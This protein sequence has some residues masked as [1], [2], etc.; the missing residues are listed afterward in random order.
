M[1]NTEHNPHAAHIWVREL[2]FLFFN[3]N[4]P[5]QTGKYVIIFARGMLTSFLDGT[6]DIAAH[7]ACR[8]CQSKLPPPLHFPVGWAAFVFV[9]VAGNAWRQMPSIFCHVFDLFDFRVI[10]MR[11]MCQAFHLHAGELCCQRQPEHNPSLLL[12]V[13]RVSDDDDFGDDDVRLHSSALC[14]RREAL[15][16]TH[17]WW[18]NMPGVYFFSLPNCWGEAQSIFHLSPDLALTKTNTH[19][20]TS[21]WMSINRTD[22]AHAHTHTHTHTRTLAHLHTGSIC[23]LYNNRAKTNPLLATPSTSTFQW[24]FSQRSKGALTSEANRVLSAT[25]CALHWENKHVWNTTQ[26]IYM[27]MV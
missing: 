5:W 19:T 22:T 16:D 10:E 15:I 21:R 11:Y 20:L 7:L 18:L 12:R 23:E 3:W 24:P 2:N 4:I 25:R 26:V 17:E 14:N 8:N 6:T 9:F 27:L 13:P 1:P